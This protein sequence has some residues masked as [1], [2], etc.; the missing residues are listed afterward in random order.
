MKAM[1]RRRV[2]QR[3]EPAKG[4]QWPTGVESTPEPTRYSEYETMM[5]DCAS[6]Q[7]HKERQCL[8]EERQ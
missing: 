5:A 7:R 1:R 4:A 2:S 3:T 8:S 6:Q